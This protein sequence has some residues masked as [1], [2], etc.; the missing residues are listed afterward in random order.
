[1]TNQQLSEVLKMSPKEF[2]LKF[3]KLSLQGSKG[4]TQYDYLV[5]LRKEGKYTELDQTTKDVLD[6]MGGTLI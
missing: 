5:R 6:I 4:K 3:A 1:M 2:F